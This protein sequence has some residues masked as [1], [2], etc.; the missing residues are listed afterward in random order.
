MAD[1]AQSSTLSGCSYCD[2]GSSI[3]CFSTFFEA[4]VSHALQQTAFR[5]YFCLRTDEFHTSEKLVTKVEKI[6]EL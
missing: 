4:D 6:L 2:V 1:E 5:L 3:V